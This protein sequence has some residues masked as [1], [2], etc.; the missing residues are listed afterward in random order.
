MAEA[1]ARVERL[2]A[3]FIVLG[4][5]DPD[6]ELL[7]VALNRAKVQAHSLRA[8]VAELQS[9]QEAESSQSKKARTSVSTE[10]VPLQGETLQTT[11]LSRFCIEGR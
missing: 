1:S 9:N 2:E 4:Q 5:D 3:A 11:F 7:N 10:L 6:A 8:Q